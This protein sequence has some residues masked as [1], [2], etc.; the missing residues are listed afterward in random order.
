MRAGV[1]SYSPP[2]FDVEFVALGPLTVLGACERGAEY[3]KGTAYVVVWYGL[4]ACVCARVGTQVLA[5]SID[6]DK[7]EV[8]K[9]LTWLESKQRE[10]GRGRQES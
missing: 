9:F 5:V 6:R 1:K 10:F 7:D 3:V 4:T 2:D 8:D